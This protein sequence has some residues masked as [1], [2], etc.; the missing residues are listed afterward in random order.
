MRQYLL[1]TYVSGFYSVA[2]LYTLRG[3]RPPAILRDLV[4][5]CVYLLRQSEKRDDRR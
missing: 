2:V 4:A 3:E 1:T 5:L